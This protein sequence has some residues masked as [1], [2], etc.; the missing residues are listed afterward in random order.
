MLRSVV[1]ACVLLAL[2]TGC[3]TIR[4]TLGVEK[5]PP[6]EFQVYSRAPL[7]VPP[8]YG[9]R[10]P[11]PGAARPQDLAPTQQA[12]QTVF[13]AGETQPAARSAPVA[14]SGRSPAEVALLRGAGAGTADPNIR[15]VV[16][17]E[18]TRLIDAER[19]FVD[20]LLFWRKPEPPGTVIDA[21]KEQQRL[22]SNVALGK[23]PT[24]GETPII[25]RKRRAI[26]E[27]IF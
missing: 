7:E 11:R 19:S 9:L 5:S 10:P 6:D 22:R 21:Q 25:E 16:D 20:S 2:L 26:L 27:G 1:C 12:R 17:D 23:A 24:E 3:D 4:R 13:R 8:D 15:Q 18:S 14:Q